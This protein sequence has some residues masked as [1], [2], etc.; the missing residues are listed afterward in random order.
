MPNE[1]TPKQALAEL[2]K[3][4]RMLDLKAEGHEALLK[5]AQ[6]VDKA[7]PEEKKVEEPKK[8]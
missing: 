1:V 5:L 7:L 6:I 3:A 8:K 2:Y 4:V